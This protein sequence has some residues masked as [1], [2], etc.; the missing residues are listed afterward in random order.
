MFRVTHGRKPY[1]SSEVE[2]VSLAALQKLELS[3]DKDSCVIVDNHPTEAGFSYTC[4]VEEGQKDAYVKTTAIQLPSYP[5]K[6]PHVYSTLAP[7]FSFGGRIMRSI[8][9]VELDTS[10]T[11]PLLEVTTTT[12]PQGINNAQRSLG[13]NPGEDAFE[14]VRIP[15]YSQFSAMDWL[16]G[17]ANMQVPVAGLEKEFYAQHDTDP[18]DHVQSWVVTPPWI[19]RKIAEQAA[20]LLE[21]SEN[22]K[23]GQNISPGETM[24]W[25]LD[26][27]ALFTKPLLRA[28]Y[29]QASGD[30]GLSRDSLVRIKNNGLEYDEAVSTSFN[31]LYRLRIFDDAD[32]SPE[33]LTTKTTSE[34]VAYITELLL[35]LSEEQ[36]V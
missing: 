5:G 28:V 17:F 33:A 11:H 12:S 10:H 26:E 22:F 1:T 2:H 8:A 3:V 29:R 6:E 16:T 21:R 30:N 36:V 20:K 35:I 34:Y 25:T 9:V 18:A 4:Q 15:G 23:N 27:L 7:E 13:R 19:C 14:L 32:L 31:S 24:A